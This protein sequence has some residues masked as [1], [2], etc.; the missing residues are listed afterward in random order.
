MRKSEEVCVKKNFVFPVHALMV[1]IVSIA[2]LSVAFSITAYAET[3]EN[4]EVSKAV[5]D[6]SSIWSYYKGLQKPPRKWHTFDFDD[7]SWGKGQAG[8]GYGR[9]NITTHLG[10]MTGSYDAIYA[11]TEFTINDIYAVTGMTLSVICDGPYTA[12]INGIEIMRNDARG[13]S[14]RAEKLNVGGFVHELFPGKNVLCVQCRNDEII[15]KDF[16]FKPVLNVLEYQG[17]RAQ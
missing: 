4:Q 13:N 16:F 9:N 17:G 1:L 6:E 7:S 14:L 11:R 8:F 3:K 5:V 2:F 12:Y 10:D 15:S